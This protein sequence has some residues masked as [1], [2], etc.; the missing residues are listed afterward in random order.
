MT[1]PGGTPFLLE[2]LSIN[3]KENHGCHLLPRWDENISI[4]IIEEDPHRR[5]R[6][7]ENSAVI[8]NGLREGTMVTKQ[9]IPCTT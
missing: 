7:R 1:V 9:I 2:C 3:A 6:R 4:T 8:H 5:C